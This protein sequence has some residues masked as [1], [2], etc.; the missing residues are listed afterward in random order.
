MRRV[1]PAREAWGD[2]ISPSHV[3]EKPAM[4][5]YDVSQALSFVATSCNDAEERVAW[6]SRIPL[7]LEDLHS[8][9]EGTLL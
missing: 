2:S 9:P 5:K 3:S 6:Q 1:V 8:K 7:L 4:T